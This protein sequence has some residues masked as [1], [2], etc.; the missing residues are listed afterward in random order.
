M[1]NDLLKERTLLINYAIQANWKARLQRFL[2]GHSRKTL[3]AGDGFGSSKK[4]W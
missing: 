2:H 1:L 3:Q 4:T